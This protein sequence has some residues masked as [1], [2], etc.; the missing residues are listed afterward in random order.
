MLGLKKI[1]AAL[2]V[3]GNTWNERHSQL[4]ETSGVKGEKLSLTLSLQNGSGRSQELAW[5]LP[6]NSSAS[7]K[8]QMTTVASCTEMSGS[9]EAVSA[10]AAYST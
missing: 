4:W 7:R 6:Q 9:Q 5:E 3:Y 8:F 2:R 10:K 1:E